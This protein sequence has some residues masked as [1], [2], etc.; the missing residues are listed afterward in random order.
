MSGGNTMK[1][2]MQKEPGGETATKRLGDDECR[3]G[4]QIVDFTGTISDT[5]LFSGSLSILR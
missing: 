5:S 2:E 4:V 1:R 3:Y